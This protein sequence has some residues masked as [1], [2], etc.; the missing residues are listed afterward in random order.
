MTYASPVR[1]GEAE[2]I[3]DILP[4][5]QIAVQLRTKKKITAVR[6]PLSEGRLA[7]VQDGD[8]VSFAVPELNCHATI[9]VEYE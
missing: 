3:E 4:V 6:L 8:M 9:V 2:I 1:R 7:F 5:Y